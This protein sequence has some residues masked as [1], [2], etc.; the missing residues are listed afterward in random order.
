MK[1]KTKQKWQQSLSEFLEPGECVQAAARGVRARFW[2]LALLYGYVLLAVMKR[3][4][5]YVVTDRNVYVF[6][7][8]GL[9][10]YKMTEVLLKRPL[11]AAHVEMNGAYLSVDGE[12]ESF[13]GFWGPPKGQAHQVLEAAAGAS[14]AAV[15]AS[16][17]PAFAVQP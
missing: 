8:S 16:N 15:A 2:N 7:A 10:K 12:H 4:R 5:G 3:Y 1:E 13:I 9:T 14:A 6:Q 11:G 17:D